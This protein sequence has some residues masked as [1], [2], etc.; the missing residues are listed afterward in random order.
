MLAGRPGKMGAVC[1]G[2]GAGAVT[3]PR[4][5]H[6]AAWAGRQ[7]LNDD[8]QDAIDIGLVGRCVEE[9]AGSTRAGTL[10]FSLRSSS[11]PREKRS[12]MQLQPVHKE[13]IESKR[14]CLS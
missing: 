7:H 9:A 6:Q 1:A 12:M 5:G 11:G 14:D 4:R 13:S 3:G 2:L 10:R 8:V